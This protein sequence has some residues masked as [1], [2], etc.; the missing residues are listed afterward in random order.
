MTCSTIGQRFIKRP[1][2]NCWC[3]S[4]IRKKNTSLKWSRWKQSNPRL[5]RNDVCP[6]KETECAVSVGTV[7]N[8]DQSQKSEGTSGYT[9]S[10]RYVLTSCSRFPRLCPSRSP[11]AA[12]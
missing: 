12:F 5:Q 10:R 2:M 1:R 7:E 8:L 6:V 4:Q 9:H 3:D 11:A